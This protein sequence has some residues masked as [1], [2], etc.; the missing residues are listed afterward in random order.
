VKKVLIHIGT[1]KTGTS[2]IQHTLLRAQRRGSLGTV[3]Y[4]DFFA[5]KFGA[6]NPHSILSYIYRPDKPVRIFRPKKRQEMLNALLPGF[7]RE[8]EKYVLGSNNIILS[9]ESIA[10]FGREDIAR[11][12]KDLEQYG[13]GEFAVVVYV[14][15]PAECYLSR[16][17]QRLK[18]CSI[19]PD[20][21]KFKY[22]FRKAIVRWGREFEG[23]IIVRPFERALLHQGCVV[24][25]MLK[26][27]SEFFGEE[28]SNI[29]IVNRNTSLSAEACAVMQRYR[30]F[31]HGDVENIFMRD[32]SRLAR[33]LRKSEAALP[34]TRP[35]LKKGIGRL[36][37]DGHRE[38]LVWL[39]SEHG[40]DFLS[41]AGE[42]AS[43]W[44]PPLGAIK[45]G[46]VMDLQ[47]ELVEKLLLHVVREALTRPAPS[48]AAPR[49]RK[50]LAILGITP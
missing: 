45:V 21:R 32:S 13:F 38:A 28:M 2:S 18:A 8:M 48:I 43:D 42:P 12:K 5:S 35:R 22:A 27:S 26:V 31:Y 3:C 46:D 25:D 40:I 37:M 50:L 9:A 14:R 49:S 15:N 36:I 39:R 19:V 4:P 7:K 16:V 6:G 1:P 24:Q 17:N 33:M 30:G 41:D 20:P 47:E 29:E 23:R 11:F 44:N 34:Q 10:R